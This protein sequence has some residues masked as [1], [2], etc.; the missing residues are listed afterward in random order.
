MGRSGDKAASS[1]DAGG[2]IVSGPGRPFRSGHS[3]QG[4]PH[5]AI[6]LEFLR[7][8]LELSRLR[9]K[10]LSVQRAA[11]PRKA[12]IHKASRRKAA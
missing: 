2:R 12:A 3:A 10:L 11:K 5:D 4:D 7:L 8:W 1:K 6:D 9:E